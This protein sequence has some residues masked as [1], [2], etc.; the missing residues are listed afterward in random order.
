MPSLKVLFA[1]EW[2]YRLTDLLR[3]IF[4]GVVPHLVQFNIVASPQ[5][6]GKR[7]GTVRW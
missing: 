6:L 4:L 2:H 7:L 1:Q 3:P 5:P